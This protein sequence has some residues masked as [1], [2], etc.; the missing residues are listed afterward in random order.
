MLSSRKFKKQVEEVG[1]FGMDRF[2]SC[3]SPSVVLHSVHGDMDQNQNL[4]LISCDLLN[5]NLLKSN[6]LKFKNK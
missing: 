3:V 1:S 4:N 2:I 5:K 6:N